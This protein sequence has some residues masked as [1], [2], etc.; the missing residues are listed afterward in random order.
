MKMMK[1][2][3]TT[4]VFVGILGA[5]VVAMDIWEWEEGEQ[6]AVCEGDGHITFIP[7]G[8]YDRSTPAGDALSRLVCGLGYPAEELAVICRHGSSYQVEAAVDCLFLDGLFVAN[9][10]EA[11]SAAIGLDGGRERSPEEKVRILEILKKYNGIID[12]RVLFHCVT[13]GDEAVLEDHGREC[14]VEVG[15]L[16]VKAALDGVEDAELAMLWSLGE[17]PVGE[18]VLMG[19][20]HLQEAPLQLSHNFK[21]RLETIKL[22]SLR[23]GHQEPTG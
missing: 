3:A 4:L 7:K 22:M 1:I 13:K 9:C 2:M 12:K 8:L 21:T 17:R 20:H 18:F 14:C 19:G 23:S 11:F 6:G 16:F 15:S 5:K 10:S